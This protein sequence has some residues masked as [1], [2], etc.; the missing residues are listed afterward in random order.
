MGLP[1]QA[2]W[3]AEPVHYG[4]ASYSGHIPS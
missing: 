4:L 3:Q 1:S 2:V